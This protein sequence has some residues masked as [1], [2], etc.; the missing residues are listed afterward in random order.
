MFVKT[1][2]ILLKRYIFQTPVSKVTDEYPSHFEGQLYWNCMHIFFYRT[3]MNWESAR[4]RVRVITLITSTKYE[5]FR[6]WI[7]NYVHISFGHPATLTALA[8][9]TFGEKSVLFFRVCA[10]VCACESECVHTHTHARTFTLPK[11]AACDTC[12]RS[13]PLYTHIWLKNF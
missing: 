12:T 7:T 3:M 9:A 8:W 11:G 6:M 2:I 4:W 5:V 13:H 10:F 1:K